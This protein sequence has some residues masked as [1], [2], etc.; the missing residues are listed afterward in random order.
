MS[1]AQAHGRL[2]TL[3]LQ[4]AFLTIIMHYSRISVT[5]NKSYSAAA[6]VLLNEL[7]KGTVSILIALYRIDASMSAS[8]HPLSEK[9]EKVA[10]S[11]APSALSMFS[12]SRTRALRIAVFSN[13]CY[14]LAIPAILYVIQNN[15]QYVAASNLDVA[16][17][18]VTYQ[19]K[20]LTTAFFSVLMLRKRLSRGKWGALVM[21]AV[22][23][24][25]VQIQSTS[26]PSHSAPPSESPKIHIAKAQLRSEIPTSDLDADLELELAKPTM[27]PWKGFVAVTAACMTSGLAGVYFELILK[28]SGSASTPPPDLWIRN[29]QLSLFSVIPAMAPIIFSPP[30]AEGVGWLGRV[31]M[32]FR[33][34]N[35]WAVGTVLTQTF[36]GLITA[37]VI[38]Y[39]DN[40]M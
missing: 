11:P 35:G 4:N 13:D 10:R 8:S 23:V 22:G 31:M 19:M 5:P 20:I 16:T 32:S 39:S 9:S 12:A 15:L 1:S 27:H 2:I 29:A 38:R 36:G 28:S 24:A 17:F 25:I 3:A 18:Q 21:L 40:I 7:L 33:N 26:A 37:V 34:F 30:G 14:K 6:A